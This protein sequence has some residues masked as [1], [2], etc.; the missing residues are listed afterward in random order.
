MA[1]LTETVTRTLCDR[2][3]K[4][5]GKG[6]GRAVLTASGVMMSVEPLHAVV[7]RGTESE[8]RVAVSLDLCKPCIEALYGYWRGRQVGP[9]KS[10][11]ANAK[12]EQP[13]K[14]KGAA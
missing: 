10:A 8:E 6:S 11:G 4:P 5:C 7:V 3:E 1:I 12:P 2:C 14:G 13:A 9:R